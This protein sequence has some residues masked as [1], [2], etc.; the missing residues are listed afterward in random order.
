MNQVYTK[1]ALNYQ[2]QI[3]HLR[4]HG[5]L[6]PD[7]AQ[8]EYWLR[9][10]SYYR[11]SA[12]WLY[13]EHPKGT[14]GPRFKAGI[15]FDDVV[16]LYDFD[17]V[18]RRLVMRGTEHVEVAL[19][20]SWAYQMAML[21]DGHSFLQPAHY[22]DRKEFRSSRTKLQQAVVRSSETYI[23]H[24]RRTYSTPKLPPVWMVAEMM[25]FGQL[26][27]WYSNLSDR[28]L[29]NRI[30]GPLGLP[31]TVLVPLVRHLTDVRNIC[32]HHGRLWNRGFLQPP[33]LAQKPLY[34]QQSLD[35]SANQAPANLYNGLTM[36]AHIVRTVAPNS[37]WISDLAA[38]LRIHPT[39]DLAAM[40]FPADWQNRPI[41]S[42]K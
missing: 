16:G 15:S 27:R 30:A 3:A 24:Y 35:F 12:Y 21:G 23:D 11:L 38:H 6:I 17:R 26:S 32:A 4:A 36:V 5:L 25:S 41:W 8:A 42:G 9:H 34:L 22:R 1:P 20:G 28:A 33:K 39:G 19:R 10:V 14:P 18:L 29:R 37:T 2:Q 31:E 7:D 13:F 40:G